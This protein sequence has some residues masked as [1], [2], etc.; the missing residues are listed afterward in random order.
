[1][2]DTFA[3][4]QTLAAYNQ[5][6]LLVG[7]ETLP[8]VELTEISRWLAAIDWAVARRRRGA[9]PLEAA[10]GVASAASSS[11]S[12]SATACPFLLARLLMGGRRKWRMR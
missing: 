3:L 7:I 4:S 9:W 8:A 1:M 10:A 5:G 2:V 11:T 12:G 6:H